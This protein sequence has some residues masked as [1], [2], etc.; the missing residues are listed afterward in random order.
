MASWVTGERKSCKSHYI[1][2]PINAYKQA[3]VSYKHRSIPEPSNCDASNFILMYNSNI[4]GF[5]LNHSPELKKE[6][7]N[8]L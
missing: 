2:P 4:N 3:Y 1:L 5:N 6:S 8:Y 7:D